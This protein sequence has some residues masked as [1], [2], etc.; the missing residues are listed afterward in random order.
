MEDSFLTIFGGIAVGFGLCVADYYQSYS[1]KYKNQPQKLKSP[2]PDPELKDE[3]YSRVKSY[4]GEEKFQD[5][6]NSFV[7]VSEFADTDLSSFPARWSELVVWE[8]ML[9]ICSS[10]LA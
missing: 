6:E 8:V 9:R 4:F 1:Q 7:I 10:D 2:N 3:L 5:L